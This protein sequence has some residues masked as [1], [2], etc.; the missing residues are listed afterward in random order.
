MSLRTSGFGSNA[1]AFG[2]FNGVSGYGLSD[3]RPFAM[4][5][6]CGMNNDATDGEGK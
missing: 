2:T 4:Q 1:V 3:F 5:G 6:F